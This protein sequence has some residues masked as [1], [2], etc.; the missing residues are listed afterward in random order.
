MIA[1]PNAYASDP[2]RMEHL[3]PCEDAFSL[4]ALSEEIESSSNFRFAWQFCRFQGKEP[5]SIQDIRTAFA[6]ITTQP[7]C[8]R[9]LKHSLPLEL[10][11]G[12]AIEPMHEHCGIAEASGEFENIL[13][14]AAGDR[15]GAYS[16]NRGDATAQEK[17]RIVRLFRQPGSYVSFI[18]S[19]GNVPGCKVCG[20][21]RGHLFSNWFYG[22]AWDWILLAAWPEAQLLWIGC[23]TDT[24]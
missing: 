8:H 7:D 4:Q 9:F 18:L 23:L 13:A 20:D 2:H 16:P 11:G 3:V 6:T 10:D 14:G 21:Y 24:D 12:F 1:E 15:L 5:V 19:P 17:E 22:V